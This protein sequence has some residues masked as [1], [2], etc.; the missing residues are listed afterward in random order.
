MELALPDLDQHNN[1]CILAIWIRSNGMNLIER[2][3]S[4]KSTN[5]ERKKNIDSYVKTYHKLTYYA[6]L[7]VLN[8]SVMRSTR[9]NGILKKTLLQNNECLF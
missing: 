6:C 9:N 4:R 2:I 8:N 1:V 3:I 5:I 7:C